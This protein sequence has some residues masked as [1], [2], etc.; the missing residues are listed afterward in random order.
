MG[1]TTSHDAPTEIQ[2]AL[3]TAAGD[4]CATC[5]SPLAPDQRYC[6]SCGQRRGQARLPVLQS[7]A[8]P[9][10]GT[11]VALPRASRMSVNTTLIAGIGTLLLAM[12]VGVLIGRSSQKAAPTRAAAPVQV[13]TVA[14]AGGAA[15]TAATAKAT[16]KSHAASKAAKA[17][18]AKQ[19]AKSIKGTTVKLP[20]HTVVK[21]GSPGHGPGY[22]NGKFTGNFFGGG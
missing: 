3:A 5:G 10:Q 8:A 13:V 1:S 11:A 2:P 6:V 12:G 21:V 16:P 20:P 18:S 14:G 19:V 9:A 7:A 4:Q 15:P 22:Q 17:P